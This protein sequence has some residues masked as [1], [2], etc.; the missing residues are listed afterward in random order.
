[1]YCSHCGNRIP[2]NANVCPY[3][4]LA[5]R[6]ASV[7]PGVAIQSSGRPVAVPVDRT[8]KMTTP[9][10][11]LTIG[12]AAMVLLS[13]FGHFVSVPILQSITGGGEYTMWGMLSTIGQLTSYLG[14]GGY[15]STVAGLQAMVGMA[16]FGWALTLFVMCIG[17]FRLVV[18]RGKG[19]GLPVGAVVTGMVAALLWCLIV[20]AINSSLVSEL[21]SGYSYYSS[22][23]SVVAPGAGVVLTAIVGAGTLVGYYSL[24]KKA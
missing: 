7:A 23:V 2:D 8:G 4:G 9:E 13:L 22:S 10:T 14:Y 12:L 20:V 3:C 17:L 15:D 6:R 21:G 1:M 19:D 5:V 18:K 11:V 24:R 16:A